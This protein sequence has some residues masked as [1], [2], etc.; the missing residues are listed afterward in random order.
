[1]TFITTVRELQCSWFLAV[2]AAFHEFHNGS[3]QHSLKVMLPYK[4]NVIN[5][6]RT[7]HEERNPENFNPYDVYL[8]IEPIYSREMKLLVESSG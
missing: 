4:Y 6:R 1:M 3:L 2:L 5:C 7:D 8:I